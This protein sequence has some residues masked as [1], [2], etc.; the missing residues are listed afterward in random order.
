M[1]EHPEATPAEILQKGKEM[2][3]RYGIETNY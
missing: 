1:R 3:S 2:M